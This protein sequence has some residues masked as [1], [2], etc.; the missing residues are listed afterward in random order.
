[1]RYL[2][3]KHR[4]LITSRATSTLGWAIFSKKPVI[5]INWKENNPLTEDAE[6]FFDRGLFLFNDNDKDFHKELLKFLLKPISEIERLWDIKE[7]YRKEMIMEF[8]SAYNSKSGERAS[9]MI[10]NNFLM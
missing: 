3:A 2:I 5:F 8:F 1:M 6:E 10:I 9:K 7:K 4:I